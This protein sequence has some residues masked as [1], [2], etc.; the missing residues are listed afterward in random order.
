MP[1]TKEES[2]MALAH[3]PNP[4]CEG[5]TQ[6]PVDAVRKTVEHTYVD[7]GGDS[8]GVERSQIYIEANETCECGLA[9]EITEQP[10]ISYAPLS[11]KDPNG[12]LQYKPPVLA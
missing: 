4:R 10:R 6:R 3:C 2:I 7:L 8:P 12:L 9:C 5:H 11:G 1:R